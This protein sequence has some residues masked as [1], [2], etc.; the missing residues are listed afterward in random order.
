MIIE[1]F[2]S[3]RDYL[4]CV[5]PRMELSLPKTI[6]AGTIELWEGLARLFGCTWWRFRPL[7]PPLLD[8]AIHCDD[9]DGLASGG[10]L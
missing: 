7:P 9:V 2:A 3:W 5:R 10:C 6:S 4:M 1:F 8:G